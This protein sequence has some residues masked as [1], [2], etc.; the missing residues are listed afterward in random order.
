MGVAAGMGQDATCENVD[1]ALWRLDI[2]TR[3]GKVIVSLAAWGRN[4]F[5]IAALEFIDNLECC[6]SPTAVLDAMRQALK[7]FG[8]D[9]FCLNGF[10]DPGQ[11]FDEVVLAS[12]VPPGWMEL[13]IQENY[14]QHDPSQRHARRTVH[15]HEWKDAPYDC[16][17]EPKARELIQRASDFKIHNGLVVPIP[18]PFGCVGQVF[19]GGDSPKLSMRDKPTLHLMALYAFDRVEQLAVRRVRISTLTTREKEVLAWA[20]KG[21]TAWEVGEILHI[22]ERTANAHLQAAALKLGTLN[23]THTVAVALREKLISL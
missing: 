2:S 6:A 11:R 22:S 21:K 18:S 14:V 7:D 17:R 15:P 12:R 5:H 1:A 23:K 10:T 3:L 9:H 20:A 19:M 4:M 13:Y 16:E 8:I